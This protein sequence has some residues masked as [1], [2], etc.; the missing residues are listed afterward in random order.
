MTECLS[1]KVLC[2]AVVDLGIGVI[3]PRQTQIPGHM[4]TPAENTNLIKAQQMP[5]RRYKC[6]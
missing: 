5:C 6:I 3:D 2:T 1:R 4:L